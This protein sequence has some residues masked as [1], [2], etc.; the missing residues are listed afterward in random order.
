M[1]FFFLKL[2]IR[3]LFPG[4]RPLNGEA[5]AP[6]KPTDP[7]IT[8]IGQEPLGTTII[9]QLRD[10]PDRVGE[11]KILGSREGD[12]HQLPEVLRG[13]DSGTT[14]RIGRLLKNGE[15]SLVECIHP[16]INR[17]SFTTQNTGYFRGAEAMVDGLDDPVAI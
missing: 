9:S 2:R 17:R 1:R 3:R 8:D 7:F 4:L 5:F 6:Q 10:R 11:P 16:L 13:E 15:S 12:F 14:V